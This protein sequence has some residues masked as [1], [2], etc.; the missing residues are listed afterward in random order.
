MKQQAQTNITQGAKDCFKA[1]TSGKYNNFA[2]FSCFVNG[3]P[4]SAIVA[5][6]KEGDG[7]EIQP[8]F[9]AVTPGMTL[10]DH[11]GRSAEVE[12]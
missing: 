3:E 11:D 1:L 2:L 6:N 12:N 7:Y 8:L 9:V 5:I 4:T 10:I